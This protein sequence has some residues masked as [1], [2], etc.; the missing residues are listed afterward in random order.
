MTM[1]VTVMFSHKISLKSVLVLSALLTA[2]VAAPQAR[3][4]RYDNN[5]NAFAEV[6]RTAQGECRHERNCSL[7]GMNT[8]TLLS[9][10]EDIRS[11]EL[12]EATVAQ[13]EKIAHAQA[14]IWGDTILEGDYD[15]AGG[16]SLDQVEGVYMGGELIAYRITYS[17]KAWYTG[18]CDTEADPSRASCQEGRIVESTFVSPKLT[19][20]MRD[21]SA[22]A[23][24]YE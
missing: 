8:Q 21:D 1:K 7:N 12:P 14:Q 13:L 5:Y 19:S 20:W 18:S 10:D 23:E 2:F 16:T 6:I 9:V 3:A 4:D 11:A 22:Y 24:F 17:E 15:A